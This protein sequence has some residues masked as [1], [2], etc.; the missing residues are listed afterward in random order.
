MNEDRRS[1]K[2]WF[3]MNNTEIRQLPE[4]TTSMEEIRKRLIRSLTGEE[5]LS[6]VTFDELL[7]MIGS[8][9]L[10]AKL[11]PEERLAG[12]SLEDRL[13][14]LSEKE[15]TKLSEFIQKKRLKKNS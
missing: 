7:A 9:K 5:I 13:S 12:L 11:N 2:E 6:I 14:G 15:L 10:L 4:F 8:E 3:R 1:K